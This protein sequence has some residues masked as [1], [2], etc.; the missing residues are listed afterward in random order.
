MCPSVFKL[1]VVLGTH[2]SF[3]L[4]T[5]GISFT[6]CNSIPPFCSKE[7][8]PLEYIWLSL[9]KRRKWAILPSTLKFLKL[10]AL[11]F[12]GTCEAR[13]TLSQT[14]NLHPAIPWLPSRCESC[15]LNDIR[16][17]VYLPSSQIG[18]AYSNSMSPQIKIR[19]NVAFSCPGIR[20]FSEN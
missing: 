19:F 9:L 4:L 3:S 17:L 7:P 16:N 12:G 18:K 10:N 11:N 13:T 20:I 8:C 6:K 1:K 14:L 15:Y 2:Q 5:Q